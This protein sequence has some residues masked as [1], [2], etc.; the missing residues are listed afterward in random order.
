MCDGGAQ[1]GAGRVRV[2]LNGVIKNQQHIGSD[3]GQA[4]AHNVDVNGIG[5]GGVIA[6]LGHDVGAV[7]E[8]ELEAGVV[9]QQGGEGVR[10]EQLVGLKV[11]SKGVGVGGDD[12]EVVGGGGA[13]RVE[14]GFGVEL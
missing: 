9:R 12:G 10:R 14:R 11:G 6:K 7:G 1:A 4:D 13:V 8:G 5:G 3:L 2:E